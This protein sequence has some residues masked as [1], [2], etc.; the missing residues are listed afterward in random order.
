MNVNICVRYFCY[1]NY[2]FNYIYFENVYIFGVFLCNIIFESFFGLIKSFHTFIK[3]TFFI[4]DHCPF[5]KPLSYFYR[6]LMA[7]TDL[8]SIH[9]LLSVAMYKDDTKTV[10]E[11][12]AHG[13]DVNSINIDT[14]ETPL[15]TASFLGKSNFVKILINA[16]GLVN[17]TVQGR[18]PL[19][20]ACM[21]GDLPTI[22]VLLQ[23]GANINSGTG[24]CSD[25][26][27]YWA[28]TKQNGKAVQT[29]IDHGA[30]VDV[31]YLKG[32]TILHAAVG[33]SDVDIV[34][35]L[36]NAGA[37]INVA[38]SRGETPIFHTLRSN[39]DPIPMVQY[40]LRRGA[41]VKVCLN[42]GS[43]LLHL[44]ACHTRGNA[45]LAH[46]LL[47]LGCCVDKRNDRGESP[48]QLSLHEIPYKKDLAIGFSK[49][50]IRHGAVINEDGIY[51]AL[52]IKN[53]CGF[54]QDVHLEVFHMCIEAG[55]KVERVPWIKDY[56]T[57]NY[58]ASTSPTDL[59]SHISEEMEERFEKHR[60]LQELLKTML[61]T[62][63]RLKRI[64]C[65]VIRGHLV[66]TA[67]GYSIYFKI[68]RLPLPKSL[69]KTLKLEP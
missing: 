57:R 28:V 52:Q 58:S 24:L 16:G 46:Y 5:S 1:S 20:L 38:D 60:N 49:C 17:K 69:L 3:K 47:H 56:L 32:F 50:L 7:G 35:L 31:N 29:L 10:E 42:D 22:D 61:G 63:E 12:L 19:V 26:P 67:A 13:F 30:L 53:P 66:S 65:N 54:V 21:S 51:D 36:T 55:L 9:S 62:P 6:S 40:L 39:P 8:N 41:S 59:C 64:C 4:P 68:S 43:N 33:H 2:I 27:L 14:K 37:D 15:M 44:A 25:A 11:L 23:N 48:L 34:T 18:K 45:Q